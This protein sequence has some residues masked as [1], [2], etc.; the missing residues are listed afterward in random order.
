MSCCFANRYSTIYR[1]IIS[2]LPHTS[3]SSNFYCYFLKKIKSNSHNPIK[4][5]CSYGP[6]KT[7]S[8]IKVLEIL[9][10]IFLVVLDQKNNIVQYIRKQY[11][12]FFSLYISLVYFTIFSF[13]IW[14]TFFLLFQVYPHTLFIYLFIVAKSWVI[15][16]VSLGRRIIDSL[17]ESPSTRNF[18][19]NTF[20]EG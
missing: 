6:N 12:E 2:L 8:W 18:L 1:I 11:G 17:S 3:D 10:I 16:W 5:F 7:M 9:Y 19:P 4:I 14:T 20:F 13:V 15:W